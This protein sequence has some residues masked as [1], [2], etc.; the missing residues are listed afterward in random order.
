MTSRR[1]EN[2]KDGYGG[3]E[4][5]ALCVIATS[6]NPCPLLISSKKG[7]GIIQRCLPHH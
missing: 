5:I 7:R 2:T 3:R 4:S 6:V 1:W